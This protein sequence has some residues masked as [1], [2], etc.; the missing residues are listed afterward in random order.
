M[1]LNTIADR[2]SGRDEM[3]RSTT[4]LALTRRGIL[5]AA[6]L[7][8]ATGRAAR[9]ENFS[10]DFVRRQAAELARTP[11]RDTLKPLPRGTDALSYE[12]Y[13]SITFRQERALWRGLPFQI[14]FFARG[15]LYE[16]PVEIYEIV[17]GVSTIVP[18][19]ASLFAAEGG[20]KLPDDLGFAGFRVHAAI[21]EP[22]R[23]DEFCVF[24]G[25]SYFRAVG[26]GTYY[27]LSARGLAIG[28]G[29]P[30]PEEFPYFRTFW[31]ERPRADASTVTIHALLDSPSVT[32]AYKF[33]IRPGPV[34]VMEIECT[35]MPRV[36]IPDWGV[37]PLTSM[38]LFGPQDRSA[39]KR[40]DWRTAVHDSDGL[41]VAN[42]N[43]ETLWRPLADPVSLQFTMLA[44]SDLRG[45]GLLQR[46][47]D[48]ASYGDLQV[49]YERRPSAWVEP[50][51]SW[52]QGAV[53]L[54]E[55]PTDTEYNDNIVA[56]W[57]GR[58]PLRAGSETRFTYRLNWGE[59]VSP[60][61]RLARV[62]QMRTGGS[63]DQ[64]IFVLDLAGDSLRGL[65]PAAQIVLALAS[66]AGVL[67]QGYSG[68]NGLP[69]GW[70]VSLEFDP[71][72][73]HVADL[74]CTLSGP[75]GP[76]AETWL[77]RWIG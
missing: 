29:R 64:R 12:Q 50:I 58:D 28:T 30:E 33:V 51:G 47:R 37:A 49:P 6:A 70:R 15:F 18:F 76:L 74:R 5:G 16:R 2:S 25:A 38:Y 11:F 24:L 13:R 72:G 4:E 69:D 77:Y 34:T 63:K 59:D 42:G 22:G 10:A 62:A 45:F 36:A 32:G 1:V 43:G 35:L 57:R 60:P 73:A 48:F 39:A 27:G 9:A 26:K 68:P 14:G 44:D 20:L 23:F 56:F 67:K 3:P 8:G 61:S 54:V 71:Q 75:A 7:L 21:N 31:L 52:G 40:D 55:I 46:K 65:D 19:S 41:A 66:S 17:D 53:D